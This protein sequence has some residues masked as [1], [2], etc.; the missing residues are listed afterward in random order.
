MTTAPSL[1]CADKMRLQRADKIQLA[2]AL[3]EA[4]R[5]RAAA[6]LQPVAV[7]DR[8]SLTLSQWTAIN[9]A[10][11]VPHRPFDLVRHCYLA[12]LYA[13]EY[14]SIVVY[15]GS[16][17]GASEWMISD[18]FYSCDV[19]E[20]TVL[21]VFP[22]DVAVSDFSTARI[23]P[24]I[25]ASPYL[26]TIIGETGPGDDLNMPP[27]TIGRKRRRSDRVTLKRVRN[28]FLYLR[29]GQV[30]VDGRAPQ[31]KA[32]DADALYLDEVDEIDPRAVPLAR[33]RLGHSPLALER[34]AST[35]TYP[36]SGIHT[37]WL[38]SDQREW[39]IRC[40]HCG[41]WQ[42]L[43]IHHVV[44]EWDAL[45]RPSVWYGG[46]DDA[47]AA[48]EKCH[49]RLNHLAPGRW[50]PRFPH[51]D[52]HGYHL[53][54]LFSPLARLLDIVLGLRE[55]DETKRKECV[56]QDLGE[57]YSPRGGRLTDEQLDACRR[58]YLHGPV[59]GEK[60]YAGIDVGK[61]IN[62]V[63][64]GPRN[65]ETGESPQ[66]WA[67]EAESEEDVIRELKR[68]NV[69]RCVMDA[70]P[71]TRTARRIQDAMPGGTVWLAFYAG[72]GGAAGK[73]PDTMAWDEDDGTVTM[74][75]TRT[76]DDLFADVVDG[77]RTLPANARNIPDYYRHMKALIRVKEKTPA[78]Q[79]VARYV[80]TE[81]D[82]YA[83][84]ENYCR[85][86]EQAPRYVPVS[87]HVVTRDEMR[88]ILG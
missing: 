32:I 8:A 54:K 31:L 55:T 37:M 78:G 49:G 25:E 2:G 53:T 26:H 10:S 30:K 12:D 71:E 24:A 63:I 21:Y 69:T 72:D 86:A 62:I 73:K 88:K 52:V 64:R 38:E 83:H 50:V 48:C 65:P 76:L 29:G 18:A 87:S 58:D 7:G 59:V 28:R 81:D 46:P 4:S 77:T 56:N 84:A 35:P 41:H 11:L 80:H 66:R 36:N 39:F 40:P 70:L 51:R 82:H 6:R 22:T 61:L 67:G 68:W 74:D 27:G 43:T 13:D 5:R 15:K 45:E 79:Q 33:K 17:I 42:F 85:A 23:G 34:A 1:Q 19:R 47:W 9:R 20:A 14:R 57:P 16:Q 44:T 75:R 3:L 60:T